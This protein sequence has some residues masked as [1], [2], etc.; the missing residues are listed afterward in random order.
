[1]DYISLRV[2]VYLYPTV[3]VLN[4]HILQLFV[5]GFA[6]ILPLAVLGY[7]KSEALDVTTLFLL[8]A[9][10]MPLALPHSALPLWSRWMF[11]LTIP[12]TIYATNFLFPDETNTIFVH[13]LRISRFIRTRFLIIFI[14]LMI[15]LSFT[16]M[17]MPPE[18]PFPYFNNIDTARYLTPSM[19]RNTVPVSMSQDIVFALSLL[20]FNMSLDS[21]IIA[22]ESLAGWAQLAFPFKQVF[23]Y[24]SMD[25]DLQSALFW[26][27][28]FD[29]IYVL[30][31]IPYDYT[32]KQSGFNL[33]FQLGLIRVY[34]K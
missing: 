8:V 10:F 27:Q 14:P 33:V 24:S 5:I 4:A 7:F 11:M 19:Q 9:S 22:H 18:A 28:I 30:T 25:V 21:C 32:I 26:A 23:V 31:L 13:R 29:E 17:V 12:F 34:V 15:L 16:Y 1:M 2:G 6:P 3:D 20:G